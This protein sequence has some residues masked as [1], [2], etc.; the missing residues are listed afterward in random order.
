MP[1]SVPVTD[2]LPRL[3]DVHGAARYTSLSP[4]TIRDLVNNGTLARVRVPLPNAGELRRVL[5]DRDEL[6][7][8]IAT[9]KERAGGGHDS[10][11]GRGAGLPTP[12][13]PGRT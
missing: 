10:S 8:M 6:D 2:L 4:W 3:L 7:Q 1:A 11:P 13:L 12:P 9:W 5:I